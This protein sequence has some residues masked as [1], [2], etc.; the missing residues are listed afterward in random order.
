MREEGKLVPRGGLCELM[1]DL[2]RYD[3]MRARAIVSLRIYTMHDSHQWFPF[4]PSNQQLGYAAPGSV[5]AAEEEGGMETAHANEDEPTDFAPT[6]RTSKTALTSATLIG[7][8]ASNVGRAPGPRSRSGTPPAWY[9]PEL[10]T[11]NL[12]EIRTASAHWLPSLL[13]GFL[14]TKSSHQGLIHSTLALL[15]RVCEPAAVARAFK[16]VGAQA[17][18]SATSDTNDT[19]PDASE[20]GPLLE[21]ALALAAGLDARGIAPLIRLARPLLT[22][23]DSGLQKKAYK[24]LAYVCSGQ[25]EDY[26][27]DPAAKA[28]LLELIVGSQSAS[29]SPARRHRLRAVKWAVLELLAGGRDE[30]ARVRLWDE[31]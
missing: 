15:S 16:A 17:I 18:K 22:E 11:G 4:L 28:L 10:A 14:G 12:Q 1:T 25:R 13:D 20:R 5:F 6:I 8:A 19:V 31:I 9:T 26:T 2:V 27:S 7:S 21:L 24:V 29:M 3:E 23:H 30:N